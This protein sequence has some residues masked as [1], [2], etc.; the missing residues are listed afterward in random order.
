MRAGEARDHRASTYAVLGAAGGLILTLLLLLVPMCAAAD[1]PARVADRK[2]KGPTGAIAVKIAGLPRGEV[3]RLHLT[4]PRAFAFS[5]AVGGRRSL[6]RLP[7]GSYRVA[8]SSVRMRHGHRS[9][10]R[11]AV[12]SPERRNYRIRVRP[13][14]AAKLE[15]QFGTIVNPG[16]RSVSG[17]VAAVLGSPAAP[18]GVV[19][20]GRVGVRRGAILSAHPSSLLPKGLLGRVTAVSRNNGRLEVLL[21]PA[22]IYDVAPNMSFDIPLSRS[23]AAQASA[24]LK[25]GPSGSSFSP[26]AKI[27]DI[28]LT[29]GWTTTRVL[30]ADVTNGATL[31]LH[32]KV[33]AGL[34]VVAGGSFSCSL[35]LPALS[36]QGMAG[37]IPVYG[38]IRPTAKGEVAAQGKINSQGSTDVTLGATV[39]ATSGTRP[40][41][42]FGSPRFSASAEV[43]TGVKASVGVDAELGVGAANIANLHLKMG[44]SLDFI[45][46]PGACSWDLNLGS[47]G[48]G[49]NIGPFGISGPSS[50]P[51]YHRN[52]WQRNCGAP[53]APPAPPPPPPPGPLTRATM[54]WDSDSDIDLYVWDSEGNETYFGDREAIPATELVEDVIPG[55]AETSHGSEV[56]IETAD[57]NRPYTFG[58]CDYRGE[59]GDVTLRVTDPDGTTRTYQHT[60]FYEGDYEVLTSSPIG[61]DYSPPW[62]WCRY[63][64]D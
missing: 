50:P 41:V 29:G 20:K 25:C 32:F 24:G 64:N 47:F 21:K 42:N 12:A 6:R 51:I 44:N 3:A 58:I 7:I 54:S 40:I 10:E 18:R 57:F 13:R 26:Y 63:Y 2:A 46:A 31:E 30:F 27:S 52:L 48:I 8:V 37:P 38:G 22:S 4:G 36:L 56:F 35:S 28:R 33:A 15:V 34:D 61:V 39:S 16:V 43:F 60:L 49:G 23:A 11:G 14:R 59:G 17:K 55:E 45:A 19:L 1:D 53:P 9:I 62:E 5:V